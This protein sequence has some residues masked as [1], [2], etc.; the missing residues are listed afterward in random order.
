[1]RWTRPRLW[2]YY[3]GTDLLCNGSKGL[4]TFLGHSIFAS[5]NIFLMWRINIKNCDTSRFPQQPTKDDKST[6]LSIPFQC[7]CR[8]MKLVL[9][10]PSVKRDLHKINQNIRMHHSNPKVSS[11][12]TMA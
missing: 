5:Q 6:A 4:S 11:Q 3:A 7:T 12:H 10:Q 8:M 9:P 1:M 2:Q